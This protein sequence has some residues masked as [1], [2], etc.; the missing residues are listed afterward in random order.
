MSKTSSERTGQGED[1]AAI[2]KASLDS[3]LKILAD[4]YRRQLLVTLL[5]HDSR[6][7]DDSPLPADVIGSDE[8][9]NQLSLQMTHVHLPKLAN[10]DIIEWD[11][12]DHTVQKGSRFEEIRP[13]VEV[14][15]EQIDER[16]RFT[17]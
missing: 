16:S 17:A 2:E 11:R 6:D 13:L 12:D 4:T 15:R 10:A 7:D 14:V 3:L 1:P 9:D 5:E 8:H